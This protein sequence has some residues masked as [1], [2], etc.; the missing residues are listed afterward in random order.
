MHG[1]RYALWIC[2]K[3]YFNCA[4]QTPCV[5]GLR[6]VGASE[7]AGSEIQ[8]EREGDSEKKVGE[9][10]I[11]CVEDTQISI[12]VVLFHVSNNVVLLHRFFSSLS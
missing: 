10:E 11:I 5:M 1:V 9:G 6:H 4:V 12:Q 3:L 8:E 7:I 2:N